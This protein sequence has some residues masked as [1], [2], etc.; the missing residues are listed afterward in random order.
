MLYLGDGLTF[1]KKQGK[2]GF[3]LTENNYET[4]TEEQ[5]TWTEDDVERGRLARLHLALDARFGVLREVG[6]RNTVVFDE[7]EHALVEDGAP[8]ADV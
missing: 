7:D 4:G 6:E 5:L 1:L 2:K 8:F 3:E